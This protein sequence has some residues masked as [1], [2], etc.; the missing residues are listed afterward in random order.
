M[1][2]LER[3]LPG[4]DA[5]VEDALGRARELG[6]DRVVGDCLFFLGIVKRL[7][8]DLDGSPRAGRGFAA[9]STAGSATR[10]GSTIALY[11]LGR[12]AFAQGDLAAARA[13]F[14]EALDNDERVGNRT[15]MA[16]VFDNLA[17]QA[18]S[19]GEHL[20][21]VRLAGASQGIKDAVGGQ[22]PP[23][24]I[25]I[26]DPRPAARE[27]LGDPAV[28]AAWEEGRAMTLEQA[29]EVARQGGP[30]QDSR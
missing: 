27:V 19:R 15:G 28:E 16:V 6:F 3:D 4:V 25:D 21:A 14:L 17:A 18:A 1:R 30:L 13:C 23:P 24:L 8:G 10:F 22:A 20:R 7:Q 5:L 29:V 26:P 2:A 11:A 12:T 9:R